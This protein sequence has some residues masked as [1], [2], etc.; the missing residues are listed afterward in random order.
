MAQARD[1]VR[2]L[3]LVP[4]NNEGDSL[5]QTLGE[6][7]DARPPMVVER[8][9]IVV[10]DSSVDNTSDIARQLGVVVVRTP[11][12]LGRDR[13]LEFALESIDLHTYRLCCFFDG[14]GQHPADRLVDFESALLAGSR[15]VNGNRFGRES[16]QFGTPADRIFLAH[17]LGSTLSR[18]I[19]WA[20]SDPGCGM[21]AI[22]S[23]LFSSVRPLLSFHG[24]L[25]VELFVR[26]AQLG[27]PHSFYSEI[28]IPA[29]YELPAN[30][31]VLKYH[32]LAEL[33]RLE[34]RLTSHLIQLYNALRDCMHCERDRLA[35]RRGT[36]TACCICGGNCRLS[37]A[38]GDDA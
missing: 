19:G 36:A 26:C 25:S 14:D 24:H 32:R 18:L 8:E 16:E 37:A 23:E 38:F 15:I 28:D 9:I 31:Q 5:E 12:V 34:P 29:V 2:S 1:T 33:D 11:T 27:V 21:V 30:K 22:D 20:V 6:L 35:G 3:V 13:A 7:L 17:V 4:C 10:D